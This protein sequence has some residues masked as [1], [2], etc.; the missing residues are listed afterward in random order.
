M[1]TIGV[2]GALDTK[3]ADFAFV[4]AMIEAR[5]Y[6]A[7]V[8]DTGVLGAPEF[9]P[10]IPREEVARAAGVALAELASRSDRGEAIEAMSRGAATIARRLY[11]EGRIDGLLGMGGSAGTAVGTSAM[12]ALPVGFPKLMVSTVAAGDTRPYVGTR[13]VVMYPSVVDVAG[14]NRVSRRIYANAV[15]AILGMVEMGSAVEAAGEAARPVIAASMFGNTT[16]LVDR[17]RK[18]LEDQGYEVLVFHATGTGGQ[19]MES[20]ISDGYVAGVFDVTTTEWADELAGGVLGAGPSRLEAAARAGVPQVVAPGCLDMVNFWGADTVPE[21]YRDRL[22][23]RWNPNVT[24]MRTNVEENAEL[25]R[26][27]AEKVNLSSGPAAV[28]LPLRGVS[29]LDSPGGRFWWPEADQALFAAIKR[30][31]R[32]DIPVHELD[33]NVN[34][35]EFADRAV[36]ELLRLLE[37]APARDH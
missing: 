19:T 12:R 1:K 9:T 10:D 13:D 37:L 26:I 35:P 32:P 21:R 27:L 15:G 3:G 29:L 33:L 16:P 24:L 22:L 36:A 31:L 34:D 17:A 14:V 30:H 23:Y 8:I 2:I 20:L 5:G 7:L 18:L 4:K 6:N 28:L 11:E 25:G